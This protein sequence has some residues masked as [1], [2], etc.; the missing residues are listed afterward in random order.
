MVVRDV[1]HPL[2]ASKSLSLNELMNK[3]KVGVIQIMT[4]IIQK[5]IIK[6]FL[7]GIM[8]LVQ[9]RMG[10]E[11]VNIRLMKISSLQHWFGQKNLKIY[12]LMLQEIVT[13]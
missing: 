6:I 2:I 9:S 7:F 3:P 8:V 13:R 5:F 10:Q 1:H 11:F 12:K 4:K